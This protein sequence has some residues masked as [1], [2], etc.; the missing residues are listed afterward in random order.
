MNDIFMFSNEPILISEA[1][2]SIAR[3]YKIKNPDEIHH[4][5]GVKID[6]KQSDTKRLSQKTYIDSII[7]SKY[8]MQEC[9]PMSLEPGMNIS[10][11]RIAN[12]K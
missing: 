2:N 7:D 5:T 6:W 12:Y 10:K 8:N 1:I 4:A 3:K 9:R 11:K